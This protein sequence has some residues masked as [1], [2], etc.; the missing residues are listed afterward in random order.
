[1]HE[2]ESSENSNTVKNIF[3]KFNIYLNKFNSFLKGDFLIREK[4]SFKSRCKQFF[5][6]I[7]VSLLALIK[8]RFL[9]AFRNKTAFMF[10]F[11]LP[12]VYI[13]LSIFIPKFIDS[14]INYDPE[15]QNY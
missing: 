14:K 3:F 4:K 10:R 6:F 12:L 7:P 11:I 1:M 13:F 2:V 8:L 15:V 5:S 9:L